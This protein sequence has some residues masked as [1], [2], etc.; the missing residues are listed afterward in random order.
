MLRES[1]DYFILDLLGSIE[2]DKN[3]GLFKTIII[4][5]STREVFSPD[6]L[7]MYNNLDG[8]TNQSTTYWAN[9]KEINFYDWNTLNEYLKSASVLKDSLKI[10]DQMKELRKVLESSVERN[11]ILRI[12]NFKKPKKHFTNTNHP[13][14]TA[15]FDE[16]TNLKPVQTNHQWINAE[17]ISDLTYD[18][19]DD[20]FWLSKQSLFTI[21]HRSRT[22]ETLPGSFKYDNKKGIEG[23]TWSND[24]DTFWL[25]DLATDSIFHFD[26]S[27]KDLRDG[28]SV[29]VSPPNINGDKGILGIAYD[30]TDKTLWLMETYANKIWHYTTSGRKL[31]EYIDVLQVGCNNGRGLTYDPRDNSLWIVNA[32]PN[33]M[34]HINKNGDELPGS[35]YFDNMLALPDGVALDYNEYEFWVSDWYS[36]NRIIGK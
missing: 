3:D 23:I 32:L 6:S 18:S 7:G 25:T 8:I 34:I 1:E 2:R 24:D 16:L 19:S 11:P 10:N 35:F 26:K 9:D 28:F 29:R 12:V 22:G 20:S 4:R 5:K 14:N 30:P 15:S 36:E 21:E 31:G 27:G 17:S 33:K 13:P